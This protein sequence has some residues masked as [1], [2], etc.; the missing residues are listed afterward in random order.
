M[1][2]RPILILQSV[3]GFC[4]HFLSLN[5]A[6]KTLAELDRQLS[7]VLADR[8][9]TIENKARKA[10]GETG[11]GYLNRLLPGLKNASWTPSDLEDL[12]NSAC[13]RENVGFGRIAQP[14]RSALTGRT[15]SP[16]IV[17]TLMILGRAE[18]IGRIRDVIESADAAA[19]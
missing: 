1:R 2:S 7:F 19:I 18:C 9:I 14:M 3:T 10:L 8:P 13:E 4:L 6:R 17:D 16:G 11:L 12:I 15:A 5:T